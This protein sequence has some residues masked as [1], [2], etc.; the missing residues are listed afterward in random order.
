MKIL[1]PHSP[2]S[3]DLKSALLYSNAYIT[4]D[5]DVV[6]YVDSVMAVSKVIAGKREILALMSD[7]DDTKYRDLEVKLYK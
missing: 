4:D 6:L 7:S 2:F 1:S 5:N 3:D